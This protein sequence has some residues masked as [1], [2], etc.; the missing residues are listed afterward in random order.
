MWSFLRWRVVGVRYLTRMNNK[1][2][3]LSKA[4]M[5]VVAANT[6]QIEESGFSDGP[7]LDNE[8]IKEI[9]EIYRDRMEAIVPK[10]TGHP[11]VN[12]IRSEDINTSN[13][14]L[15]LAFSK[16]VLDPAINYFKGK[17]TLDSIQFLYSWP[18][19]GQLRASQKWHKDFGDSKSFHAIFYLNDVDSL[20]NGPFTFV[21]KKD[22]KKIGWS[23]F[24][25]RIDDKDFIEQLGNG[26]VRYF[27]GNSGKSVFVDP[28][29]CYHFGSRCET[30]RLALFITFNSS[31]PFVPATDLIKN[32]SEKLLKIASS[33]RPDLSNTFLRR[34]LNYHS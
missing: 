16:N 15:K 12:L 11:F 18:T 8:T 25:R 30:P 7:E 21:D 24:I 32:N 20:K 19:N 13:P 6:S 9:L 3:D 14:I 28:A 22:S 17:V 33:L 34:M 23:F 29:V 2:W 10:E 1:K 4:D 26:K 5:P 31:R 27:Y